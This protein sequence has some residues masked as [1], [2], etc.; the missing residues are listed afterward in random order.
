[1]KAVAYIITGS[2][3]LLSDAL[4]SSVNLVAA[5]VALVVLTIAARPADA[6]HPYGHDKAEYFSAGVEGTMIV[7]AA[8]SIAYAAIDRLLNPVELERLGIGLVISVAAALVNLGVALVLLRAGRTHRS[9]TLEADGKHLMTDVVTSIGVVVGLVL[10][11]ITGIEQFDPIIAL[12]VSINIVWTAWSLLR[13]GVDGLM[14]RALPDDDVERV[15]AV[16]EE[17]LASREQYH[18]LRTRRAGSRQFVDF[19][20]LVPGAL[21]VQRAHDRTVVEEDSAPPRLLAAEGFEHAAIDLPGRRRQHAADAEFGHV[22][23][24]LAAFRKEESEAEL[25]DVLGFQMLAQAECLGEIV[26]ADLDRRFTDLVR[27]GGE[28]MARAFEHA[29]VQLREASAQLQCGAKPG[30]SIAVIGSERMN[31]LYL[32]GLSLLGVPA[33]AIDGDTLLRRALL[34]IGFGSGVT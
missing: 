12:L 33:E 10:A 4:E 15:R 27:R 18:A 13:A 31:A 30:E 29:D 5:V 6:D 16:I 8:L 17:H 14:D 21:S 26:R 32:E 3:G 25:A 20:L 9:I 7:I 24:R 11:R 34:Q 23:E 1:M 22:A 28:R 19:H 2:V